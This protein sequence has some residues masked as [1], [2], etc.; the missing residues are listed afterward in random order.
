MK[1]WKQKISM[2]LVLAMLVT[3]IPVGNVQAKSK[4]PAKLG[5]KDFV[6]TY[7]GK[8]TNFISESDMKETYYLF[9][10]KDTDV[11]SSGKG[12]LKTNRKVKVGSTE[13]YV[14]KQYGKTAK[15]K[16]NKK[17]RLYKYIKYNHLTV[18]MSVWK[19]YLE[20]SYKKGSGK[21]KIRFYLDKKNKVAAIFYV[22]NL[23]KY[24]NYPN[25]ELNPGL[26]FQPP[27]GKKLTTKVINGRKVYMIPRGTKINFKKGAVSKSVFNRTIMGI[28]M[29]DVYGKLKASYDRDFFPDLHPDDPNVAAGIS[30]GKGYD[31]EEIMNNAMYSNGKCINMKKLGKYLYFTIICDDVRYDAGSYQRSKSPAIYC[32]KFK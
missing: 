12:R 18:D 15:V 10:S 27:K 11:K 5:A 19:N 22:K 4:S 21:Y 25:K 6:Y 7:D 16:V 3:L 23:E 31:L 1:K 26:I 8:K 24:Y 2:L 14:K 28:S 9:D 17:E 29:Y 13:S 30:Q 20:Y 32:F